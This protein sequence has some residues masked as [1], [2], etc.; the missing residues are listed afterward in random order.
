VYYDAR[1]AALVTSE[2]RLGVSWQ[3]SFG[4]LYAGLVVRDRAG[5]VPGDR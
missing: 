1:L 3:R 4:R 5:F 2:P